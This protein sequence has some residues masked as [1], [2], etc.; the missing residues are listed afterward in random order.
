MAAWATSPSAKEH[1]TARKEDRLK[2]IV[3]SSNSV[4][5]TAWRLALNST[6]V[7]HR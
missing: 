2:Y 4:D 3:A 1:A 6:V 7:P 5:C